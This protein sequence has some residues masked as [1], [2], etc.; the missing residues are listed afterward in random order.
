LKNISCVFAALVMSCCQA[1]YAQTNLVISFTN[2]SGVF[3]TNA[4]V[5]K[6]L[7]NKLLYKTDTGGGTIRLDA[8]PK[9]IQAELGFDPIAAQAADLA[10]QKQRMEYKK[11][12]LALIRAQEL[13]ALKKNFAQGSRTISGRI[14]QKIPEGLLVDS[15]RED[16]DEVGHK[17]IE[18]DSQ[19]NMATSLTTTVQEGDTAGA[20]CLGL[21][22]LEDHP[23]AAELVDDNVVV[24][25]GYPDGQF[26][27]KAVS[28]GQKTIR[29]FTTDFNKAFSSKY[30]MQK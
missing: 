17:D 10:E 29:K 24:T 18:F 14:I 6:L 30:P 9:N 8:L 19:G 28:G 16:I 21:V 27:Y 7:G 20:T 3:V 15:G 13:D 25:I 1:A 2:T 22:L 4:E 26:S 11:Q 5:E 23:R 12:S